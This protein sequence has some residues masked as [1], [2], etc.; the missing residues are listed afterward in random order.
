MKMIFK[1][2][3]KKLFGVNYERLRKTI[4]V[5]LTVFWGLYLADFHIQI[6]PSVFYLMVGTLTA[7]VMWQAL[8][9]GDNAADMQQ[10]LMLPFDR[11]AFV[12]SYIAALGAYTL[13]TK[14]A[15]L[16]AVVLA[17][18]AFSFPE[19]LGGILCAL[20][21]IFMSAVIFSLPKYQYM[22]N[23]WAAVGVA[24]ILCLG[25][26]PLFLPLAAANMLFAL[27]LLQGADGYAFYFHAQ[28]HAGRKSFSFRMG[29][30]F[31]LDGKNRRV[32]KW[33]KRYSVWRY[34]LRYL[35]AHKNY[36]LNTAIMW[37][38]ACILPLFLGN[39]ESRFALPMGFA[40]LSLNTP[41]C[42][43]LSCDTALE[44][45]VRCLPCQK[46]MFCIPYCLFI[47]VCNMTADSIFLCSWQLQLGGVS[48]L[49]LAAA[50][51][52]ALQSA[53]FS[54]L[55]EW[56]FPIRHWKIE[57]DLWHHPRKYLVPAIMLLLAGSIGAIPQ[58]V[59]FL[60][61]LLCIEVSLLLFL[62]RR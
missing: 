6:A 10:L 7:S 51:F 2:F 33:Y 39:L 20:N 30:F 18:A 28:F 61:V 59:I 56:F 27:L 31:M 35:W 19:V 38:V 23:L 29:K 16:L 44:Q 1:A 42:I 21:A 40:I 5:C 12:F 37:G 24:V 53:I 54:V 62:C 34:L 32:L 13:F 47:F 8:S 41:I 58:A 60:M 4:L 15:A 26:S 22:G 25:K 43:L 49:M 45:A 48:R 36:L 50:V 14:T 11:R 57:S 55:L 9:S 17:V 46:K 52:T 3:A